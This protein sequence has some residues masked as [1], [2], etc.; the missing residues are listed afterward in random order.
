MELG[1]KSDQNSLSNLFLPYISKI[2]TAGA[3]EH[4]AKLT[5]F[6]K[7]D[8]LHFNKNRVSVLIHSLSCV[9]IAYGHQPQ[10][11]QT[12][13]CTGNSRWLKNYTEACEKSQVVLVH[14]DWTIN[15]ESK[16]CMDELFSMIRG[17]SRWYITLIK[18]LKF[19]R[20]VR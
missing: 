9:P 16:C 8:N 10:Y 14:S 15:P 13:H 18:G 7:M 4:L 12:T 11:T 3:G 2:I 19:R 6:H 17:T 1:S 5:R 20:Y